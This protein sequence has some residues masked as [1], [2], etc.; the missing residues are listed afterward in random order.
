[1]KNTLSSLFKKGDKKS[2]SSPSPPGESSQQQQTDSTST[3]MT[4]SS[5]DLS[6]GGGTYSPTTVNGGGGGSLHHS[7]S[8]SG[9]GLVATLE[10]SLP[11][12]SQICYGTIQTP[13]NM[14]ELN[15]RMYQ[16]NSSHLLNKLSNPSTPNSRNN[17][18]NLNGGGVG[19]NSNASTPRMSNNSGNS[20]P[21]LSASNSTG[22]LNKNTSQQFTITPTLLMG[23]RNEL[24]KTSLSDKRN[25][26]VSPIPENARSSSPLVTSSTNNNSSNRLSLKKN[27]LETTQENSTAVST[28]FVKSSLSDHEKLIELIVSFLVP[29]KDWIKSVSNKAEISHIR[30]VSLLNKKWNQLYLSCQSETVNQLWNALI[31]EL[32]NCNGDSGGNS[33][34]DTAASDLATSKKFIRMC[35]LQLLFA[36]GD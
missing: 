13:F 8:F 10:G 6:L 26:S 19:S 22:D 9:G 14:F 5:S 20:S 12:N 36:C 34:T 18:K 21:N 3:A 7:N 4:Y 1:M 29:H 28:T 15:K 33:E 23:K 16:L 2:S 11:E 27:Q 24:N 35:K 17:L 30:T 32:N 31:V 25:S